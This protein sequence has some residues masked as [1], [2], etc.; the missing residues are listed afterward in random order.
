MVCGAEHPD[1]GAGSA[2][3]AAAAGNCGSGTLQ[4]PWRKTQVRQE[5]YPI[6]LRLSP[7]RRGGDLGSL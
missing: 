1:T 4:Q 2:L 5:E 3:L 7:D 6:Q